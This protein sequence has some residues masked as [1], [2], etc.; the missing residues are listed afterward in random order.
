MSDSTLPTCSDCKVNT[1]VIRIVYGKP[2]QKLMDDAKNGLVKL[3]G[4]C[5]Q[6]F[7]WFCKT[8]QKNLK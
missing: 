5:P 3:G 7:K 1:N 8:C 4:C 6:E 2:G